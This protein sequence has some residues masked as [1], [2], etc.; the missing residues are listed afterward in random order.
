MK[1]TGLCAGVGGIVDRLLCVAGAVLFSQRP[2]FIQQYLQRLEGH[3]DEAR[4]QLDRLK[5][6][7]SQ[8]GATVGELAA[9]AAASP[10]PL[11]QR[12][13]ILVRETAGRVD[14]LAADDDALR[15]ASLLARPFVFLVHVE[16]SV[17]RATWSIFRPAVPTTI[18]GLVYACVG[19]LAM[20][21]LYHG[22][23][24]YPVRRAWHARAARSFSGSGQEAPRNPS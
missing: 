1:F 9:N 13:G 8:S 12:L 2:E 22:G 6:T 3:L 10:D 14:Q 23:V 24:R 18:E 5:E 17:A 11:M 7:A 15:H 19:M 16:P 21:A 4:L 20:L